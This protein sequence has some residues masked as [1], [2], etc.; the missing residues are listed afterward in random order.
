MKL[1]GALSQGLVYPVRDGL[2]RGRTVTE[3]DEVTELLELVKYEP[4]IPTAMEGEVMA[5]HGATIHYDIENVKKYPDELRA[6]EPVVITE[7]CTA[8]GAAWG[9]TPTTAPS[10]RR[11]ACR[12]AGWPSS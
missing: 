5:A 1:R 9:G 6:G 3:G 4:P 10:S 8:R 2:V 11:R 7:S 12:T